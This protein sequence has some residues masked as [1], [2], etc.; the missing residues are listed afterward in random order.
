MTYEQFSLK[1]LTMQCPSPTQEELESFQKRLDEYLNNLKTAEENKESEEHIKGILRDFLRQAFAYNS[2][3]KGR[4]D[5]A[6]YEDSLPKVILEAKIPNAPKS[7]FASRDNSKSQIPHTDDLKIPHNTTTPTNNLGCTALYES[8]LYYLREFH[9]YK[10]N[11]ITFIIL[12]NFYEFYLI[13]AKQYLPFSKD[14][15]I[16]R[17]FK[18]CEKKEGNDTRTQA[19]Y[20]ALKGL[21]PNVDSTLKYTYFRLDSTLL[22]ATNSTNLALI[23]QALSPA[24][25][26]KHKSYIDANTLNQGFYNELLYILG[27][28]ESTQNGKVL[29]LPSEVKNTLLDTLCENL[30]LDKQKDFETCFSLLITWNNRLLFLRLSESMLLSFKHITKP[31]LSLDSIPSFSALNTLFFEV[32]AKTEEARGSIPS[33]FAN[34]PYLNSSLF[35]KTELEKEGKEIKLLDSK[36][37]VLYKDSILYKDQNLK[38]KLNLKSK[39]SK[40]PL[41]EYLFAF[42]HAYNFTTT[43]ENIQEHIK[44]NYDKLIN[45]AI[46]G[47][48]F[49]KLNGYKEGSF[50]T[51]SFITSYMCKESLTKVVLEKFNTAKNWECANL[52]ELKISLDKFTTNKESYK[53]ANAIFDSIRICDPAVGSGHFLVSALNEMVLLKFELGILCDESHQRLKDIKLEIFCDELVLRD[54]T[55]AL[56]TYALPAHEEIES[57]KIQKALFHTKRNLIES[58]LF[59]VDINP[60]SCEITKLRLWIELLKYSYYKDIANKRLETLPNIDINIKCGNSLVSYFDTQTSLSHYPNIKERINEYKKAVANYKEGFYADKTQID[61]QIKTL[62]Q[63]FKTFCLKDKFKTQIKAFEAK[64]DKYSSKYGNFLAKDDKDL[65]FYVASRMFIDTF[66]E[67]E[68]QKA[69]DELKKEYA[70]IFNLESNKPFE[71]RFAFPEVLDA[72]GDFLG[73]D[74]IIGNPPYGVDLSKDEREMYKKTYS[75]SQT[76]TA[77]LF[78]YLSDRILKAG[79]INTLIVPKSLNYVA[80]WADVREFIKPDMYLLVDCGKAWDYVL[81]EMVIFARAKGITIEHYCTHFLVD[82]TKQEIN[83]ESRRKNPFKLSTYE[84]EWIKI[85]KSLIGLFGFFPSNLSKEEL[86]LGVKVRKNIKTNLLE[87]AQCFRGGSFQKD[88]KANSIGET[89]KVLGGKEIQRCFIKGIKGF[90][91]KQTKIGSKAN[92]QNNSVLLQRIIAHIENPTPH[93]KFMATIANNKNYKIVNTIFQ[94]ICNDN[95][96]NKYILGIFHSKFI[97]WYCYRFCFAKAIRSMDFSNEIADKIPIPKITKTNQKIVNEIIAL[98]DE[99]L[100]SKAKDPAL[101]THELESQIDF[102]VYQLYNLTNK[103]IELIENK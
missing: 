23:F 83:I 48:V 6:I 12:T 27:L 39:D 16:L 58:C 30:R 17:A 55:N 74:L 80:K 18:N 75:T 25:L 72:N 26:L 9:T 42:L 34:I 43:Q 4:I 82:G 24:V 8:I 88:V 47:L 60:N 5:L 77:A 38:T 35:D 19:F 86:R 11:N 51:P 103:E 22:E 40:L 92:I 45:A 99:I 70:N 98:V 37:L 32:L 33:A 49:E 79:G 84:S 76:N 7:E 90:V 96:P 63:A 3:T 89:Y 101:N 93:I 2:N 71:W 94:I 65:M 59:G 61:N 66:N 15:D 54:S 85:D 67:Q 36:P 29:I 102:L 44:T 87:M 97:N 73:F 57:H 13:D 81:L 21:L 52:E 31:F 68:A 91:S 64:C 14:K 53:E 100:D 10:N 20:D 95:V 69:F 62:H 28:E 50:Y 56:F 1:D 46:L 41:L 78:M